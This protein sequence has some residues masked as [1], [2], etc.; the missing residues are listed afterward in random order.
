MVDVK[1]SLQ[2]QFI[3]CFQTFKSMCWRTR[4]WENISS[5]SSLQGDHPLCV[6]TR[7]HCS[8]IA[9]YWCSVCEGKS[10]HTDG[11]SWSGFVVS[12][13]FRCVNF[14]QWESRSDV[15]ATC[16][17]L[18]GRDNLIGWAKTSV[19][20]AKE[21]KTYLASCSNINFLNLKCDYLSYIII[22]KIQ[23]SLC[24]QETNL[25]TCAGLH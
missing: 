24:M 10:K 21:V 16:T 25:K 20:R 4:M 18:W 2:L 8:H 12:G 17:L 14:H 3:S 7:L 6:R 13:C 22:K 23:R 5:G 19:E 15:L 1:I 11:W 9:S